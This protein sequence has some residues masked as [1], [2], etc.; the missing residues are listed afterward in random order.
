[1]ELLLLERDGGCMR[2]AEICSRRKGTSQ[3]FTD[4]A[5]GPRPPRPDPGSIVD[6]E[7]EGE[8]GHGGDVLLDRFDRRRETG[9]R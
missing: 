4:R 2:P 5:A 3:S 7:L 9:D 6:D 1:M 8:S